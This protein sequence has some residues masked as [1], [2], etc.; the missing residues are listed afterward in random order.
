MGST[1]AEKS[2]L[3][4]ISRHSRTAGSKTKYVSVQSSV[5]TLYWEVSEGVVMVRLA[6]LWLDRNALDWKPPVYVI[7]MSNVRPPAC[8][9]KMISISNMKLPASPVSSRAS[10]IIPKATPGVGVGVGV[11]VAVGLGVAVGQIPSG[12]G[13]AVGHGVGVG[14]GVRGGNGMFD[15]ETA[16][17]VGVLVGRR[18]AVGVGAT[19]VVSILG[20]E[21]VAEGA[22]VG[23]VS[24]PHAM[25]SAMISPAQSPASPA[26]RFLPLYRSIA[27]V[28]R[29]AISP[30]VAFTSIIYSIKVHSANC[31]VGGIC[32]IIDRSESPSWTH[33]G[34]RSTIRPLPLAISY[35]TGR[36]FSALIAWSGT[37]RL[38][39]MSPEC[40]I[41]PIPA[42]RF[43]RWRWPPSVCG[44]CWMIWEYRAERCIPPRRWPSMARWWLA[45]L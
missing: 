35:P 21:S 10:S 9:F 37:W 45:R 42:L 20:G 22:A 32:R 29:Y 4:S 38:F 26:L 34:C 44:G 39:G 23:S 27:A 19:V 25:D 13:V 30:S 41:H 40:S 16:P 33:C 24:P 43:L 17:I 15:A 1:K 6:S 14:S 8:M 3:S 36:Y 12:Q 2:S 7:E 31:V 18:G 11:G 5:K 28:N